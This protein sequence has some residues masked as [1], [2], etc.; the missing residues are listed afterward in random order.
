MSNKQAKEIGRLTQMVQG[1]TTRMRKTRNATPVIVAA[2]P[3]RAKPKKRQAPAPP[4]ATS[5][6]GS[7]GMGSLTVKHC[8]VFVN[9]IT[10]DDG[11]FT[12]RISFK[13]GASGNEAGYLA[14][15]CKLHERIR[16]QS[17]VLEYVGAVGTTEGGVLVLGV[18]WLDSQATIDL[19]HVVAL[20]PSRQCAIW[21][22]MSMSVPMA[23]MQAQPWLNIDS[24]TEASFGA[25]CI[26]VNGAKAKTNIGYIR[27]KY[28]VL[29][30]GTRLP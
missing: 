6:S 26:F 9:V 17:L 24:A 21:D 22:K 11:S 15:Q 23:R 14:A 25:L 10:G 30:A 28:S 8:E 29:L 1:L 4:R 13:P 12:K 20:S 19:P 3:R 18:D 7:I 16:W 5:S 2:Q 27:I